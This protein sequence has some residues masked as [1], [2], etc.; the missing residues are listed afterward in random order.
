[1]GKN[2][3]N[4]VAFATADLATYK[5]KADDGSPKIA[6]RSEAVHE[7]GPS[8]GKSGIGPW[9]RTVRSENRW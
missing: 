8:E 3:R 5:Q 7:Q 4:L 2:M 1:M 9:A 6:T